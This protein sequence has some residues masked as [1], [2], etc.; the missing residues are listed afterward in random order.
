MRR[1]TV[2]FAVV[3]WMTGSLTADATQRQTCSA[4]EQNTNRPGQDFRNFSLPDPNPTACQD[5]CSLIQA[6]QSWTYVKPGVQGAQARCWLK[7][8]V[9]SPIRD[10]N[11]ISGTCSVAAPS[12]PGS[13][14]PQGQVGTGSTG[15]ITGAPPAPYQPVPSSPP[16]AAPN[17]G[18]PGPSAPSGWPQGGR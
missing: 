14:A 3:I 1:Y 2:A 13:S 9:P 18:A 17:T 7:N 16:T 6:C 4:L 11:C 12:L 5:A 8:G 10:T 15:P